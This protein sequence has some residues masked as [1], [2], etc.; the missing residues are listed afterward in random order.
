M[1][2]LHGGYPRPDYG[3]EF[4]LLAKCGF[5]LLCPQPVAYSCAWPVHDKVS[6]MSGAGDVRLPFR[7][8]RDFLARGQPAAMLAWALDNRARFR[9]AMLKSGLVDL[10]VRHALC[11]RDL[12]PLGPILSGCVT[13]LVP[14]LVRDLPLTPFTVGALEMELVAYND[15]AH[16][17][18]HTDTYT[19]ERGRRGDRVLSGVYYFHREPKMF[20]GGAL[21]L[22]KLGESSGSFPDIAPEQNSFVAFHSWWPHEVLPVACPSRDFADSRFAVNVWVYRSPPGEK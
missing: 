8:H 7:I 21:R 20:S 17:A 14:Q 19:G 3:H 6:G 16:F 12:G 13:G 18:V 9:P 1:N 11:L 15:G 2:P 5:E 10:Q 22:H 4:R